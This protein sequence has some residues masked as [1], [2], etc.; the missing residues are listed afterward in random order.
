MAGGWWWLVV[1]TGPLIGFFTPLRLCWCVA[2]G[3]WGHTGSP[4]LQSC[5]HLQPEVTCCSGPA[6][7]GDAGPPPAPLAGEALGA[8]AE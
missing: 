4:E 5:D 8:G 3:W 6:F 2:W 1:D 7:S